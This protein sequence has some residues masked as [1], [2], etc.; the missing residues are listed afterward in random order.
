MI[1]VAYV[2]VEVEEFC[3]RAAIIAVVNACTH[4]N[5][6]VT[7]VNIPELCGHQGKCRDQCERVTLSHSI[8]DV[9]GCTVSS[10]DFYGAME[11]G[12]EVM[13]D[14]A[15]WSGKPDTKHEFIRPLGFERIEELMVIQRTASAVVLQKYTFSHVHLDVE[16]SF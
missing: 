15:K 4:A 2:V 3:Q 9:E 14:S 11:V 10:S 7:V 8:T 16:G 5:I 13:G 12:I 6:W 1:K